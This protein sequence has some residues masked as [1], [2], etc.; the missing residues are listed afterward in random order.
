MKLTRQ[1]ILKTAVSIM[2]RGLLIDLVGAAVF[3][4]AGHLVRRSEI[5]APV[6]PEPLKL[7]GYGLIAVSAVEILMVVI[8]KRK[9]LSK[10]SPQLRAIRRRRPFLRQIKLLFVILYLV[11]LTPSLYGFLYFILGGAEELFVI[12]VAITLVGYMLT[13]ARPNDLEK[14]VGEFDLEDT[15]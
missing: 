11:A 8:L 10:D 12:M 14:I 6:E 9:W 13:R 3:F 7:L 4:V 15:G 2:Y 5:I 1:E